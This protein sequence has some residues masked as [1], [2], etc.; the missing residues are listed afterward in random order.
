MEGINEADTINQDS[1]PSD[2]ELIKSFLDD[3]TLRG[4]SPET[5]RSHRSNLRIISDFLNDRGLRFQEV[6]KQALKQ[7][8]GYLVTE[9]EVGVKTQNHYFS[10]LSSFYEYLLYDEYVG[11]NPVLGFRKRYLKNYKNHQ[12]L[13]MRKLLSVD[14]M[15]QLLNGVLGI[16]DKALMT[17]LAKTGV[18]RGELISMDVDDVD[19]LYQRIILKRK[20]KRSNLFVYFD[21]ETAVLLNRWLR[22]RDSYG[23]DGEKALF[24]GDLGG[25][26]GRNIVYQVVTSHAE[27]LGFHNPA[28]SR[29]EDHF[30][31]H[32]FRHWFTTHLRRNGLSREFIKELRGDSRGE[33]IDIY[34]HIDH[35][36]LRQAYLAAIPRLGII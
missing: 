4:Y 16:R 32:C 6:D 3:C 7:L 17:V 31:P 11:S 13:P 30:S 12:P 20:N 18:R 15:T 35:D 8:L 5:I 36:E 33:A 26:I 21:E 29:L 25:R 24:V 23:K 10:V 28:S 27:R 19:W 34:D 1:P 9:R 2:R 14:E 22:T